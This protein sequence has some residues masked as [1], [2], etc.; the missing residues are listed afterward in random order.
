MHEQ[1]NI[2]TADRECPT[3]VYA[4]DGRGPWPG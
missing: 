2:A 1:L 4:P 3:Y